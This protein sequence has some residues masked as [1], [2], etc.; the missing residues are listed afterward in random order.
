VLEGDAAVMLGKDCSFGAVAALQG[1]KENCTVYRI[2]LQDEGTTI[3]RVGDTGSMV[4]IGMQLTRPQ[5]SSRG[6]EAREG[7]MGREKTRE[8]LSFPP[9]HHPPH[10]PHPSFTINNTVREDW[11]RVRG[12]SVFW[13]RTR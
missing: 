11:E 1:Y 9:S 10:S 13:Q 4:L 8:S 5:S 6:K 7:M 3:G 2:V 12:C